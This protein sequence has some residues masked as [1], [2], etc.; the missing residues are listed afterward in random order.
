MLKN[1][2]SRSKAFILNDYKRSVKP[3]VTQGYET[4]V[5]GFGDQFKAVSKDLGEIFGKQLRE[6][7]NLP[8][9]IRNAYGNGNDRSLVINGGLTIKLPNVKDADGFTEAMK[10]LPQLAQQYATKKL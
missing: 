8:S 2:K 6:A 9:G 10:N 7:L 1:E 3:E 4:I 5:K